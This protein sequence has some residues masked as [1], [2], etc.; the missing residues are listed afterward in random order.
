M[1]LGARLQGDRA[2][3]L[4]L[5]IE[6]VTDWIAAQTLTGQHERGRLVRLSEVWEKV[7]RAGAEADTFNLD[8]KALVFRIFTALAEAAP[9]AAEGRGP[10]G[11]AGPA[12]GAT[13][14]RCAG[15]PGRWRNVLRAAS[16][17]AFDWS[18]MSSKTPFYITTAI[19]YPNGVPHMGH[20]YEAIATDCIARFKRL[21][22]YDVRFLTG[23]DEHGIKMLQTAQKAGLTTGELLERNVPALPGHGGGVRPLQ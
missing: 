23:T 1:A 8:R 7:R 9:L 19:A 22:G 3:G 20:A 12:S 4:D 5:F 14:H 11:P 6:A 13:T 16:G 18:A 10:R 2:G 17:E 15:A 21:D